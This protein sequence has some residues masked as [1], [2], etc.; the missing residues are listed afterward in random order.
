MSAP[1][2]ILQGRQAALRAEVTEAFAKLH[3]RI[4]KLEARLAAVEARPISTFQPWIFPQAPA[5]IPCAPPYPPW[6]TPGT[7]APPWQPPQPTWCGDPP[8]SFT[9]GRGSNF[10]R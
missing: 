9:C 10:S 3:E 6:Q 5:P 7:G 8:V 4:D 1:K 2:K